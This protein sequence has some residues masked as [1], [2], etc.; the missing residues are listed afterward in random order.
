M[1]VILPESSG[2]VVGVKAVG[3]LTDADYESFVPQVEAIIGDQGKIKLFMDLTEFEGWEWQAAWDDF[4][5]GIKHWN[6]IE[7]M[8]VVGDARWEEL[9]AKISDKLMP[10]EVKQ[11]PSSETDAAWTWV[12]E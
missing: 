11:F 2:K 8:A 7:K 12:R 5:F 9:C 3:K 6:D 1:L 4:A 10:A